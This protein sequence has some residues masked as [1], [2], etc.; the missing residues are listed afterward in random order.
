MSKRPKIKLYYRRP[1]DSGVALDYERD[2]VGALWENTKEMDD[3]TT[4]VYYTG[5][6]KIGTD[7]FLPVVAFVDTRPDEAASGAAGPFDEPAAMDQTSPA[8]TDDDIPF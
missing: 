4:K 1:K 7:K 5:K 8:Q 6:I 2:D 3:G